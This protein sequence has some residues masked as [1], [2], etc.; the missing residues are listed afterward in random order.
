MSEASYGDVTAEYM[1]LRTGAGLVRPGADLVWVRGPDAVSF[2][3]GLLSQEIGGMAEGA[4]SRSFLLE[5]RGKLVELLR[6]LRGSDEI[7]LLAGPGRGPGLVEALLKF[8]FRVDIAIDAAGASL[9]LWGPGAATV[10]SEAGLSAPDGWDRY[11][12]TASYLS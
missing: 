8:K 3:D 11:D 7:G 12:R 6:V 9:E 10:L 1:A 2:L 4:T 5:P